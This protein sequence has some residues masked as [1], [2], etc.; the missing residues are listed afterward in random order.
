MDRGIRINKYL[1]DKG[2]STRKGADALIAD[3]LVYINGALAQVGD[4][5][6]AT[7]TVDIK[8]IPKK[9]YFYFLYHKP[10][11]VLTHSAKDNEI[12]IHRATK[13]SDIFPLGR[14]DKESSGLMI[15]TNDGRLTDR[16]LNPRYEHEKE[17]IVELDRPILDRDLR[18]IERGISIEGYVTKP[19]SIVRLGTK[20]IGIT[21]TEGKKHQVRRMFAAVGCAVRS[22][23][24][25]RIAHLELD[26]LS[27]NTLRPLTDRERNTLLHLAGLPS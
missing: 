19:A 8:K 16:L 13:R 10:Q 3:G 17:Y 1:A 22:L 15:L 2:I 25:I 6:R 11:G 21:I 12:D 24:R 14:L 7:D 27:E 23:R 5:V 9:E 20:K 18:R 4:R 26:T